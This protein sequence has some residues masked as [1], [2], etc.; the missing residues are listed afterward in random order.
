MAY[1]FLDFLF[2][3]N[4]ISIIL[5]PVNK[6]KMIITVT[7]VHRTLPVIKATRTTA[8]TKNKDDNTKNA[9]ISLLW[10]LLFFVIMIIILN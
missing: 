8:I 9:T 5:L 1:H 4:T 10:K 3:L 2:L 7:M 6:I